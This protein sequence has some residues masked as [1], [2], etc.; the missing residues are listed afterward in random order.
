MKPLIAAPFAIV[1]LAMPSVAAA[2]QFQGI[3]P[4]AF[5]QDLSSGAVLYQRDADRRMPPASMAKMMTVYVAF[6]MIK[7]GELKLDQM[8]TVRP[9]TW[10]KWHGPQAG[11]TMFLSPNENVSV[12]NLLK[13]IVT[14]SGNDACVV[15]AE[16]IS[17]TEQTFTDRMNAQ[18]KRL[19]LSNSHFGT[20]NGWPDNGVTYVTARDLAHLATATIQDFPDLYK[21]FYSLPNFTWG[22][23][24]G[25]GADITQ[26]NRDPLLGRVAGADGLKTG[27]T[28][29]AGYGFTGSAE[30]NGRR[31]V[32][33][34]AGLTSSKDRAEESVR[35]MEW[36]FR[37]W[38]AKPVVAAGKQV[39]TAE[40]QMGSSSNV[41]LVAPRQLTVTLPAGAVPQ[42]SA[43]VVYE[44]PIKA[45]ITKGQHI[46]DLV[47]TSP[48]LPEQRLPLVAD[49][50]VGQAGFFGRA[51]A[52]LTSFFG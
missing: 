43:K 18:A 39:S 22:K 27:H 6:D 52:G 23:T 46:A 5:M 31:L 19:G 29:E 40:V 35:F 48:D 11:S 50:D 21:R 47:V 37:A 1:A 12:E 3:A 9:E 25:A 34:V 4:I 42:M 24:L 36:G 30:Q 44:G 16:G 14:L 20:A 15:L 7:K 28:E 17:G 41:G 2:P 51:W 10:A 33:V 45:P 49:K 32:M 13:G 38:Q 8:I 26:A